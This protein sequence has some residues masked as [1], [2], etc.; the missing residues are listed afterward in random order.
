MNTEQKVKS[1]EHRAHRATRRGTDGL[2]GQKCRTSVLCVSLSS[3]FAVFSVVSVSVLKKTLSETR[4]ASDSKRP[5]PAEPFVGRR[6]RLVL[7][8]DPAVVAD[9]IEETEEERVV[10]LAGAGLVAPRIVGQLHMLDQRQVRLD[11]VREL[12]FHPLHVVD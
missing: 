10:D 3:G 4:V 9:R 1:I 7:A 5:P 11:R 12:A 8:A 6:L 2:Q